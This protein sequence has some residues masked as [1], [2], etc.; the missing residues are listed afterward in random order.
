MSETGP[1]EVGSARRSASTGGFPPEVAGAR[2]V[3]PGPGAGIPPLADP[4]PHG[5]PAALHHRNGSSVGG[6]VRAFADNAVM[7]AFIAGLALYEAI[8]AR[9]RRR[10]CTCPPAAGRTVHWTDC[11]HHRA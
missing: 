8:T 4:A 10:A 3:F 6:T 1:R 9:S 11:P 5:A 2:E 7:L